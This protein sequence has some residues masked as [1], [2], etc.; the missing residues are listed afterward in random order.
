MAI[1]TET[2]MSQVPAADDLVPEGAYRFRISKAEEKDSESSGKPMVIYTLKIQDEGPA[3]GRAVTVFASLA[4]TALMTIKSMYKACGYNPGPEGHD[5]ESIV[6][7]ELYGT[8]T[9]ELGKDAVTRAVI[10]PY[11]FKS[12]QDGPHQ[13]R[14]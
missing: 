5:P 11:T 10:K 14:R 13:R 7:M 12:L 6:D 2:D 4:P 3:F 9:H 8:I 1:H